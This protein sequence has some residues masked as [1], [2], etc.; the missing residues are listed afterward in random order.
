MNKPISR[1]SS[2][3]SFSVTVFMF[4]VLAISIITANYQKVEDV[5]VNVQGVTVSKGGP[6]DYYDKTSSK[7][8][9]ARVKF[10][11]NTDLSKLFN[12]NTKQL[13]I[14]LMVEYDNTKNVDNKVIIWDRI[15]KRNG[16]KKFN[17]KK[18]LNKYL[19][20]DFSLSLRDVKDANL[21]FVVERIPVM[22]F[23]TSR[24]E[25]STKLDFPEIK[26]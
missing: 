6:Y 19:F 5:K 23:F 10:D 14:Y 24:A 16:R 21:T 26:N 12:W 8:D 9:F 15:I 2:V 17:L 20:R 22:G 18:T 3:A 11:I 25:Y 7:A 1:I 4:L 13:F